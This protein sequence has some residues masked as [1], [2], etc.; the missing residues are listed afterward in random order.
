MTN[1]FF[2]GVIRYGNPFDLVVQANRNI[3]EFLSGRCRLV[4]RPA[5]GLKEA[6]SGAAMTLDAT[7]RQIKKGRGRN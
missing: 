4:G 6:S 1:F 2:W 3:T 7:T 5:R